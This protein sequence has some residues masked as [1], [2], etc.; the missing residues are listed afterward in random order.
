MV[1]EIKPVVYGQSWLPESMAFENGAKDREVPIDFI[2]YY[3]C[4]ED[5][6]I[7][8]DAGC[9][10][11]PGF[12]MRN[13]I[14][15]VEALKRCGIHADMITDVLITHA[16]HDHIDGVRHFK[17]ATVCIQKAEYAK[18]KK[19][20]PE[21]RNL[22]LFEEVLCLCEGVGMKRIGGH[23]SGSCIVTV[24]MGGKRYIICGDECYVGRCL[25]EKIPTGASCCK[26]KSRAFIETYG[27]SEYTALLCHEYTPIDD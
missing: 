24:T 26:E 21:G 5:R 18:G 12:D 4:T 15:P 20:I 19:Y 25:Q 13:H 23:T 14:G 3:I 1:L 22:R 10:T 9:D 11:L 17:N 27:K 2:I 16:H 6:H 7:L 8:V